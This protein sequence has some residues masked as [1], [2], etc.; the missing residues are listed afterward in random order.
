MRTLQLRRFYQ[1]RTTS[2]QQQGQTLGSE[3]D[4]RLKVSFTRFENILTAG[5][6]DEEEGEEKK[7]RKKEEEEDEEVEDELE[8]E[9]EK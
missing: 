5:R 3:Q 7:R 8:E 1:N 9:E 4:R 2:N 6:P